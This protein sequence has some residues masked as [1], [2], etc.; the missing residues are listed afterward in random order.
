MQR[1]HAGKG[2]DVC[3]EVGTSVPARPP[4]LDFLTLTLAL[5]LVLAL[6]LRPPLAHISWHVG[7]VTRWHV[8]MGARALMDA[9]R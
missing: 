9:S 1:G 8:G 4:L 6:L 2:V 3:L 7:T 5:T